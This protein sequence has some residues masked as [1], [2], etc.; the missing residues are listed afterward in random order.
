MLQRHA[1]FAGLFAA[2]AAGAVFSVVTSTHAQQGPVAAACE[3]ELA[4]LCAGK[5]HQGGEARSC[6]ESNRDKLSDACRKA[7]DSTGPGKGAGAGRGPAN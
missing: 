7:L 2:M 1:A 4:S 6:L 5:P 3:A